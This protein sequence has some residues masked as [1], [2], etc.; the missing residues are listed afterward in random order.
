V[1]PAS[2]TVF[3]P[4]PWRTTE[5]IPGWEIAGASLGLAALTLISLYRARRRPYLAV[6]WFWYVG[7][8]IPVIGL[9]QVGGQAMADRY[10]YLPLIGVFIM[11]AWGVPD[12]LEGWR[13]RRHLL[14]I[15]AGLTL[16][17]LA[18]SAWLQTSHWKNSVTLFGHAVRVSPSNALAHY[19]LGN[20]YTGDGRR[21]EAI[22]HYR[23]AL[24]IN[25]SY[26]EA[27]YN[28][29]NALDESGETREAIMNYTEVLRLKPAFAGAHNNLGICLAKTGRLEEAISHFREA[30]RIAPENADA[31]RNLEIALEEKNKGQPAR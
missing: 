31:I 11:I 7:T 8:L 16:L 22:F 23:Q 26:I 18:V 9:V 1:W 12:L 20:A 27:R 19:F 2:L 25:P 24:Q 21:E 30:L 29:A 4:H 10:T 3:Y 13:L 15:A 5:S 17:A 6:G 14:G 28:L